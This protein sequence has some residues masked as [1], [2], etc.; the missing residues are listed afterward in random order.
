MSGNLHRVIFGDLVLSDGTTD[1]PMDTDYWF[2]VMGENFST[3]APEPI[4]RTIET[5][6]L[7]G[8]MVIKEGDGNR[9]MTVFVGIH[10]PDTQVL[11]D[12]EV[13]L[14][15]ETGRRNKFIYEPFDGF[16]PPTLF[17]VVTSSFGQVP[18]DLREVM[19]CERVYALSII[20]LPQ[21]FSVEVT[22]TPALDSSAS[23]TTVVISDGSSATGWT[24]PNGTVTP[25]GGQLS[26]PSSAPFKFFE[27]SGF[28][29]WTGT[30]EA[31][32]TLSPIVDF[33]ATR[34]VTADVQ[35][36]GAGAYFAAFGQVRESVTALV[37]GAALPFVSFTNIAPGV[38]RCTWQTTDTSASLITFKAA[39]SASTGTGAG[40]A[41][42]AFGI[43]NV[44]RTNVAPFTGTLRQKQRLITLAGSV[45]TPGSLIVGHPSS[46]LGDA[47]VHTCPD[48]GNGYSAAVSRFATAAGTADTSTVSGQRYDTS[49]VMDVPV[50]TLT[51]GTYLL[52][53][54]LRFGSSGEGVVDGS[55]RTR[56]NATNVGPSI[57]FSNATDYT[58]G[59]WQIVTLGAFDLPASRVGQNSAAAQRLTLTHPG[60]DLDEVWL[61][62]ISDHLGNRGQITV[63]ECGTGTPV[64]GGDS[65]MLFINSA[66]IDNPLPG[67]FVGTQADQSDAR[68][69]AGAMWGQHEFPPNG[70]IVTTVTT[71]ALDAG[72]MLESRDAGHSHAP[73]GPS[74]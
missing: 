34:Y 55:I 57:D 15:L 32:R 63:A 8:A 53:A 18:D 28:D 29:L 12:G 66:T 71:N 40:A 2:S 7:D 61:F 60:L 17:E 51:P 13:A 37:D 20:A 74:S 49:T 9:T 14:T 44:S 68:F 23:P 58:T 47:I 25:S 54:R 41:T 1:R 72:T 64:A 56:I 59:V 36:L 22:R 50:S 65:N 42:M 48:F 69:A 33:T 3:G 27:G 46:A 31:S 52:M 30:C 43:D 62:F 45:R 6:M 24:S 67:V 35:A 21:A 16:G 10:G 38:A 70:F 11:T 26:V 73:T 39:V 5:F 19:Q 4:T